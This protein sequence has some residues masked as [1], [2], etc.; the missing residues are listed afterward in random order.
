VGAYSVVGDGFF[1]LLHTDEAIL[2]DGEVGDAESLLL[3][4]STGV[5]DALVLNLRGDDMFLG[6]GAVEGAHALY[7]G[8]VGLGGSRGK[9]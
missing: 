1:E 5:Q 4:Q 7:D 9:N 2:A 6:I 8:V 3:E